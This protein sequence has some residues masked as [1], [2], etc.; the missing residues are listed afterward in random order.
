MAKYLDSNGLTYLWNKIKSYFSNFVKF[1]NSPGQVTIGSTTKTFVEAND[2]ITGTTKTKI[3]Y[4]TKGLVT[5]GADLT[6]QDIPS[7]HLSKI[8]DV[9]ATASEVNV[10]D[11][12]TASTSELNILDGVTASTSEIN[13]LDGITATTADLNKTTGI[14]AGAEVNQ[15]AFSNVKVGSTTIAADAKTDTLEVAGSTNI[16]VTPDA[17]NDKITIAVTG[18]ANGAEVNQNAF[19]NI[20]VG[21]STVAAN[22]KTDTVE[23]V[24]SGITITADTTNDKITF[25][26]PEGVQPYTSNPEMNGTASAGSSAL[27]SRGDHVH[28]SDTSKADKVT[29]ATTGNLAALDVNGNLV[30][31][32][33]SATSAGTDTKNTAGATDSSAKL[34]LVGAQAQT[35]NPQT[36]T[37]DTAYVGTD[38]HLYS[39]SKQVVNLSDTQTLTNKT[40][41]SPSISSPTITGIPLAPTATAGTNTAQVATT[42]FVNTEIANAVDDYIP[43][44]Q[45]GAAN[46]VCPLDANSL[47]DS[48]YL[49]SYVDDVIEAYARTG[50]TALSQ[51]WLAIGSASGTPIVPEIGKIYVLMNSTTDYTENTQFRWSGT[52]YVKL[53]DGGISAMTTAEMDTATS[54]WT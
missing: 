37:Q 22:S 20:K 43:L 17:T 39:N 42:A 32:G 12:V 33:V 4:D 52:T 23:F 7:L 46:G 5:A 6:E 16:T 44:S 18:I 1:G 30:D 40:L 51:N 31:S 53:N 36:Y 3:T 10:L 49:P 26:A 21:A 29:G 38:G 11:G 13:V 9:T 8:S 28:P 35:A 27:Y 25:T 19:S 41:T 34:F 47:I 48:Q 45:K 14:E 54:N 50:Q 2:A 15:N 24:G